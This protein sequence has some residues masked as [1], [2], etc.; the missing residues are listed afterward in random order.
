MVVRGSMLPRGHADPT[1][2]SSSL[3]GEAL[4]RPGASAADL[5]ATVPGVQ[6]SRTGSASDLA[7]AA[8]RGATSAQTPVYL[9]GVRLNDDVTG[10]ADLSTLPLALLQRVD[11]Y[12]G[13]SPVDVDRLGIGGAVLF[14]PRLPRRNELSAGVAAGSFAA[15]SA[16]MSFAVRD[17]KAAALTALQ[18]EAAANDFGF[19]APD[20]SRRTRS[21]ADYSATSGWALGRYGWSNGA[22]VSTILHAYQREQ[23]SPGLALVPDERARSVSRRL[24]VALNAEL[25]CSSSRDGVPSCRVQL[26]SSYLGGESAISDPLVE[27]IASPRAWSQGQRLEQSARLVYDVS[28]RVS[29]SGSAAFAREHIRV[30]DGVDSAR[31]VL[32]PALM[33][34]LRIGA[35]TELSLLA[36]AESHQRRASSASEPEY[37]LEPAGRVG[38]RQPLSAA[39]ELRANLGH[40]ARVPTLGEL[41]G[42]SASVHGNQ[43]LRAE[44]GDTLDA[45][46]RLSESAGPLELD[47]DVFGFARRVSDLIAYRQSGLATITPYN[48]GRARVLGIESSAAL[49]AWRHLRSTLTLTLLDARDT[50]PERAERNE[51]LP[52]R[53]RLVLAAT[54]EAFTKQ[55]LPALGLSAASLL[56]RVLHRGSKYADSAGLIVIAEQTPVDVEASLAW[57]RGALAL[58]VAL[59]NVFDVRELDAVGLPLPGRSVHFSLEGRID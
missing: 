46:V 50:T 51:L 55:G 47:A 36:A 11:V 2:A 22:R 29:L 34:L 4:R 52:F 57:L 40:Y 17:G 15:R 7:T 54:A 18:H 9:A 10:T 30:S 37:E 5:L 16:F 48:V 23:G 3:S 44:R 41:H 8:I 43:S 28:E 26:I 53:S 27:V 31:L 32:R 56:V 58:R 25:P 49:E 45:G 42:V 33:G 6:V 21:N 12:R 14:E 24:L 35:S 20:G 38:L 59:R 13:N 1:V 19:S 39:L